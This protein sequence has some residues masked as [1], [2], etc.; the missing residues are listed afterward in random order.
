MRTQ[1]SGVWTFWQRPEWSGVLPCDVGFLADGGRTTR[2][3]SGLRTQPFLHQ[4]IY[5]SSV[6]ESTHGLQETALP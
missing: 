5:P 4:S 6:H 2:S 1:P 3:G